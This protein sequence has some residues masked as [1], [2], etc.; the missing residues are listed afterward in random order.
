MY[1]RILIFCLI[2]GGGRRAVRRSDD[3]EVARLVFRDHS[4]SCSKGV[5]P[6][7]SLDEV[8]YSFCLGNSRHYITGRVYCLR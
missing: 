7:F 6:L 1:D 4:Q 5:L 2:I 3:G 8:Q